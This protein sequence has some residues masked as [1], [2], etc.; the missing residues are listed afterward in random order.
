MCLNLSPLT[1][2]DLDG[3][4]QCIR[5]PCGHCY[6]CLLQYQ[7]SWKIRMI[8]EA[9]VWK[10]AYFFTL[11]YAPEN[12]PLNV[13]ADYPD[14][15]E[16]V[17]ELRGSGA[18]A[19]LLDSYETLLSTAC[20]KDVQSWLKR[21]RTNYVRRKALSLGLKV[22]DVTSDSSLYSALKPRFT[23]FITA[24]YAP[25]GE[26]TDRHGKRR[27]SSQRP[28]YHGII[29]TDIPKSCISILFGD[30]A[31]RFGF[32]KWEQVRQRSDSANSC[33]SCANYCAKYCCKG[34][35]SSRL[36]DIED[37][38]IEKPWRLVSKG[39]GGSYISANKH[40]H[41]PPRTEP[42]FEDYVD[43]V[44]STCYYFDGA[45]KYKLPRYYYERIFFTKKKFI[46]EVY[47][48]GVWTPQVISRFVSQSLLSVEM[49]VILRN[50]SM[51]R[52]KQRFEELR[53]TYPHL[54]DSELCHEIGLHELL[55]WET[56]AQVAEN[57]L[58]SFY[59][60]NQLKN[61]SLMY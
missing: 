43:R 29:F 27:N 33:S 32:V 15:R 5:V 18:D 21:F 51:E 30:W 46:R 34:S 55:A 36:D 24:E 49:Q 58:Y 39:L 50:R 1:Y 19:L 38:V 13:V 16:I 12:L 26:Y 61:Q 56:R 54:S 14:G 48:D 59:K 4:T 35:F 44:L 22:R 6:E 9:K 28:H 23:Y 11:T 3:E 53:A 57:K 8:E 41:L 47:R 42:R 40:I 31:R 17:G 2:V 25:S 10:R 45:F 37:G 60:E 7:N 52:D 20:K